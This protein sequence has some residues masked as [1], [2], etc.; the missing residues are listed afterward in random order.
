MSITT[1]NPNDA[2]PKWSE[3]RPLFPGVMINKPLVLKNGDWLMP[4][5][6]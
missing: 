6:I 4:N 1:E 3:P 2:K 5:A